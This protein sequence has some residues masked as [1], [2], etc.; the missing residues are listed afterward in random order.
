MGP[1]VG[2]V[3]RDLYLG[4]PPVVDVSSLNGDRFATSELRPELNIV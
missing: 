2:E 4:R 3:M 1:A